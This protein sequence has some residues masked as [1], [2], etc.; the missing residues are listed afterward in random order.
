MQIA[1]YGKG[2]IGKSTI[3]ANISYL[4]SKEGLKVAQIGCDPKHDS[5][6]LLLGGK[7]QKTVLDHIGSGLEEPSNVVSMGKND[8]LCMETGGP[9]PGV[10]CAGRGILTAFNFINENGL[11]P[12]DTD[13][14]LYDVLGDVVCGGFAVPLRRQYSDVIL[15]VT[16]GEFMS[17]YAANNVLKG[18]RNFDLGKKRV[19][20][21][22]L[23]SRGNDGEADYVKNFADAVGL[24]IITVI[25][26]SKKFALA[27]SDGVTVSEMFPD[28]EET[29][30]FYPIVDLL[31]KKSPKKLHAAKPLNEEQLDLIAK[32]L[33]IKGGEGADVVERKLSTDE[34][35]TLK[36]CGVRAAARCCM[37]ILDATIVSHGP[38]SCA[39]MYGNVHDR[40]LLY[41][42]AISVRSINERLFSSNL[43]DLAS[44]YGG[45]KPLVS[46]IERR[47]EKGDRLIFVMSTCVPGII[48]D[49]V[50]NICSSLESKHDGVRIIPVPMDGILCGGAI[51]GMEMA[52]EK[53]CGLVDMSVSP[54]EGLV[55]LMGYHDS[56]D[57]VLMGLDDTER[58]LGAFGLSINCRLLHHNTSEDVALLRRGRFNVLFEQSVA[59]ARNAEVVKRF[60]GIDYYPDPLPRG[61]AKSVSWVRK[62]AET[63]GFN[64]SVAEKLCTGLKL[65]YE[66]DMKRMRSSIEGARTIIYTDTS[67]DIDWLLEILEHLGIETLMILCPV[68]SVWTFS[69]DDLKITKDVPIKYGKNLDD[70]KEEISEHSPNFVIGRQPTLSN[71]DTPRMIVECPRPG[72]RGC[73]EIARRIVRMHKVSR[74]GT[75]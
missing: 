57:R 10:G 41:T 9:E 69:K 33:E 26:R 70:L 38:M 18:I 44:I 7:S 32:G 68:N 28:S 50:E 5:T 22:I 13:V 43:D 31:R 49:D 59:L 65:E 35:S 74:Y 51:H 39:Y 45:K 30:S 20:G 47:L 25:P 61:L 42:G 72:V 53:I 56:E 58:I 17:L 23:N 46:T 29:S 19:A 1:L 6:R 21:L 12:A 24:P 54:G 16:S 14:V 4:L 11:I 52:Y 15:I 3:S 62:F 37:E 71:L 66:R 75:D 8:V 60:T 36:S 63:H 27:E 2:G 48:G 64:P 34:R 40:G 73:V 55:N 67:S